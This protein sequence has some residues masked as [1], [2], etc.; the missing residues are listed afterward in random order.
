[1]LTPR[2]GR[3]V[4]RIRFFVPILLL[5]ALSGCASVGNA[6]TPISVLCVKAISA[7]LD[8]EGALVG[9]GKMLPETDGE[10][11]FRVNKF[12]DE[13]DRS[14]AA[15]QKQGIHVWTALISDIN[16]LSV[17]LATAHETDDLYR[18]IYATILL[19]LTQDLLQAYDN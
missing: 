5:L 9:E 10:V 7:A 12:L 19:D 11:L 1:M 13:Y 14:P 18:L 16:E 8:I 3:P 17:D 15:C 4:G 2:R 6:Q